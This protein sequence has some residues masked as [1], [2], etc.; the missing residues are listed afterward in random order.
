M[1]KKI[2][3]IFVKSKPAATFLNNFFRSSAAYRP[4]FCS[5]TA[6]LRT[7][8]A[9]DSVG[10]VVTEIS[11]LPSLSLRDSNIP[12]VALISSDRKKGIE[13]AAAYSI[14]G[15]VTSPF[16]TEDLAFTL[17][18]VMRQSKVMQAQKKEIRDPRT[19]HELA[20]RA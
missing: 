12:R 18:A 16:V 14:D 10:A 2:L 13:T 20:R 17:N 7:S 1:K 6:S 4:V 9:D 19:I 5:T 3:L 8:L 11:L 15:Y